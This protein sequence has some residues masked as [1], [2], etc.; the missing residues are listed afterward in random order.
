MPEEKESI[1]ITKLS[2]S[3]AEYWYAFMWSETKILWVPMFFSSDSKASWE[4]EEPPKFYKNQTQQ[5]TATE[6]QGL[7]IYQGTY[8]RKIEVPE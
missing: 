1:S 2:A 8:H 7:W 3:S 5:P 6:P 4:E